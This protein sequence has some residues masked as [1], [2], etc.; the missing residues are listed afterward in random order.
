MVKIKKNAGSHLRMLKV[1]LDVK[2]INAMSDEYEKHTGR[3]PA[4]MSELVQA[5]L[6]RGIPVDPVGFAYEFSEEGKAELNLDSP[7]LEQQ[8]L[9]EKFK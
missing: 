6:L 3:R 2:A 5:G 7:L 4:R 9:L 1:D 8:L